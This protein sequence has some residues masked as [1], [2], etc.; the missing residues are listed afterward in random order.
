MT[1]KDNKAIA[2]GNL[3]LLFIVGAGILGIVFGY[4]LFPSSR[5]FVSWQNFP[6]PPTG[7]VELLTFKRG[8]DYDLVGHTAT[9]EM[10]IYHFYDGWL[11]SDS[12]TNNPNG[13]DF[14]PCTYGLPEFGPFNNTPRDIVSCATA[15]AFP[16]FVSSNIYALDKN[17][18]VWRWEMGG[19]FKEPFHDYVIRPCVGGLFGLFA[20]YLLIIWSRRHRAKR[21]TA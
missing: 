16:E 6:A 12:V 20:A 13:S 14:P 5:F 2:K 17:G 21:D 8:S 15:E 7:T 10:Y 3:A 18:R 1:T 4:L 9:G 11:R 19:G